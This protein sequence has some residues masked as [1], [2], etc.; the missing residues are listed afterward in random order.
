MHEKFDIYTDLAVENKERFQNDNVEISGVK[1]YERIDEKYG[2]NDY[3][4]NQF[5]Q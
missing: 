3:A 2:V 4:E 1:V 5:K